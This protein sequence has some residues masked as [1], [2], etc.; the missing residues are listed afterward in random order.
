MK[1]I[2]SKTRHGMRFLKEESRRMAGFES[3]QL[4]GEG[5]NVLMLEEVGL[6][7]G[8]RSLFLDLL[9]VR[10]QVCACSVAQSRLT[11]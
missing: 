4:A 8:I 9:R 10:R 11:L 3:E 5:C 1:R 6:V 2:S 7:G